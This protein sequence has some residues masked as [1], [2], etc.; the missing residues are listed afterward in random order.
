MSN[1]LSNL[2]PSQI[3][4]VTHEGGP[5]LILAGAGSGKTR[6]LTYRAAYLIS[7]KKV[8]PDRILLTTF[9]NK[10]AGEMQERLEI[11]VGYRL[12][13]AG[14]FH[15]LCARLLRIHGHQIGIGNDYLIYDQ[16]DSLNTV[17]HA[18][19]QL[20]L[21]PKEYRPHSILNSIEGAKHEL[22]S[23]EEYIDY[24][25]GP[26]QKSVAKVYTLYQKLLREYNALDFNDLLVYTVNLLQNVDSVRQRYQ[27][28]F[29][30]VLVDEYQDT[31]RTQYILTKILSQKHKNVCVVGDA[32][33]AIYS[34]RGADYRNL[35]L[36]KQDFPDL[37][38]IK[39]EQNYRSTQNILD[40]AHSVIQHN[41]LHPIL[42]LFTEES[43]GNAISLHQADDEYNE[44]HYV[45]EHIKNKQLE[46]P[47]F[48]LSQN[49][50]LYRTNAQ[51]RVLEEVFVRQGIPYILV[52]GVKFYERKEVKDVLAYVRYAFNQKDQVSL[53]RILKLGKRRFISFERWLE[54]A[55]LTK[56]PLIIL[57]Q[58]LETTQY[59]GKY[60]ENIPED[61]A[62]IENVQELR[63]V[64]Q[65]FDT[66]TDFL[67]NVALV[68]QDT[69]K[70]GVITPKA[71]IHT[72]D[73][74][75][76]VILMT[77]HASKGLEFNQV[78]IIGMEEGLFPHSR[79]MMSKEELE[80]ERRL[81][82][83]GI[84]RAKTDLHLSYAKSRIYF[85]Q[86]TQNHT[87]RF[88]SELPPEVIHHSESKQKSY[89]TKRVSP[90]DEELLD[91]FLSDDID[92]D[93]FLNS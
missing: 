64:A 68:E 87:S 91:K 53:D 70:K 49:A 10:A 79:S 13:F 2:N 92:I 24:A 23:P 15:S 40:A 58:I 39:L 38:T 1:L 4:A 77:L 22:I 44:V 62:R 69:T 34:W 56:K 7:E 41:S 6:A 36:L 82:Y 67:E 88:I 43:A 11:L 16:S 19:Q 47:N 32:S 33:Q 75:D 61:L 59:L 31:N 29:L 89:S 65:N 48:K 26:F 17:K 46:D 21:D 78:F 57:D 93:E 50:V 52:G 45:L 66:L 14:T 18:M 85:G 51:S 42:S 90:I 5:L 3:K 25:R 80:E 86:R 8:P 60:D 81:C 55:D 30:H 74:Q 54:S 9:T 84:T 35:S 73:H 37:T 76:A 28:Q 71:A 72:Q 27:E 20:N 63:S 12:P 83:V